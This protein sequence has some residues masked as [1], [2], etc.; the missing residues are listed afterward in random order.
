MESDCARIRDRNPRE[1]WKLLLEIDSDSEDGPCRLFFEVAVIEGAQG[2]F[3]LVH[4]A[5]LVIFDLP[6]IKE[7]IADL[8]LG[9]VLRVAVVVVPEHPHVRYVGVFGSLAEIPQLDK[10]AVIVQCVI[11]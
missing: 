10:V 2:H 9:E 11:E 4:G 3:R 6:Q 8:L 1:S 5:C 7:V